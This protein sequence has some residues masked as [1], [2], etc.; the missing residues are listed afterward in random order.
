MWQVIVTATV[1]LGAVASSSQAQAPADIAERIMAL[2]RDSQWTLVSSTPMQF[3]THHPQGMVKIGDTLFVS[4]V[5]VKTR[6]SAASHS[7]RWLRSRSGRGRRPRVQ[8]R[9]EGSAARRSAARRRRHLSSRRHRLRRAVHLGAGRR[10]PAEQPRHHLSRRSADHEGDRGLSLRAITSGR[11]STTSTTTRCTAPAGARAASTAGRSTRQEMSRT[12]ATRRETLRRVEPVTLHRL[13]GLQV[14]WESAHG[15]HRPRANCGHAQMRLRF[16]SAAWTSSTFVTGGP[17]HQVPVP[18]VDGKRPRHDSQSRL[19]RSRPR[20][21]CA[22]ISCP[23]TTSPRSTSTTSKPFLD[24][25][26]DFPY[27]VSLRTRN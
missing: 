4:S 26:F 10:V 16:A 5:E 25:V 18:A 17:L 11:S 27:I 13:P 3:V 20:P 19:A 24:R 15:V 8:D 2:T 22:A 9:H 23:K 1:V 6:T 21:V 14:R 12:P 7:R